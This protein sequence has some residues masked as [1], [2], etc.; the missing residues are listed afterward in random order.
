MPTPEHIKACES[1]D[2]AIERTA[3][4]EKELE[5]AQVSENDAK[6]AY[7]AAVTRLKAAENDLANARIEKEAMKQV[8]ASG[9][10]KSLP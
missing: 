9:K 5:A 3:A 8:L 2:A 1:H 10:T 6:R 4:A 7:A